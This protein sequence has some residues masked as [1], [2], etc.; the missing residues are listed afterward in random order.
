MAYS[1]GF[2]TPDLEGTVARMNACLLWYGVIADIPAAAASNKCVLYWATDELL[3]YYSNGSSWTALTHGNTHH[4]DRS[5]TVFVN[6]LEDADSVYQTFLT[7]QLTDA[8]DESVSFIW[9]VPADYVSLGSVKL[10][11]TPAGVG[12][13]YWKMLAEWGAHNEATTTDTPA[14]GT[15][16]T[17]AINKLIFQE[18]SN[19]LTLSGLAAGDVV[20]IV[21]QRDGTDVS[22]TV[23][24][25]VEVIGLE[26]AY[27]ADQ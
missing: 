7:R 10:V 15:T 18:P 1:T 24:G 6:Y 17:I 16:S 19:A 2:W 8:A 9:Q 22:D 27:T 21:A 25:D 11:Y 26:I 23:N 12:N 14:Y 3:M 5:R 13:M 20:A 4:T